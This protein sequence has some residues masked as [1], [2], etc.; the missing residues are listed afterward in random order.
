MKVTRWNCE[1]ISTPGIYSGVPMSAYHSADL[2]VGPSI[3]S[4]GLRKIFNDSPMA[5]W[6]ESP[7][8][9]RRLPE[10]D[11]EA[12]ILG[13]AAHHLILGEADF[14]KHFTL[15]PETYTNTKTGEVKTWNN[16]AT[17]C[18][19]WHEHVG[20]EGL[21]V[22]TRKQVECIRGMAGLLPWQKGL[23]D[24]G[25]LNCIVARDQLSG[26]VEHT[27]IA[28]DEETGIFLKSRPD[29][30]PLASA[31][32]ADFK[33]TTAVD[34]KS[35]QRTL[36]DLRYDM[37]ADLATTCLRQAASIEFTSHSFIFG[38]KPEP[39]A[40]RVVELKPSD[41]EEARED[42][43]IAIRTFAHC[44]ETGRW[45]GPGGTQRDAAFAERSDWSRKRAAERRA[46]LQTE[47]DVAA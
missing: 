6:V 39:H 45:P 43:R 18:R 26:L 36:D 21:T 20:A 41:L 7:L 34:D 32:F 3:S 9:P 16:N 1:P 19:E 28:R 15:E 4:S 42:N 37:Q 27:I 38:Q 40:I 14:G 23:E 10:K 33:T 17:V 5:Y 25:L 35:I 30:I 44:L 2:C 8:N 46:F 22:L 13:R 11:K 29:A 24:S 31:E 47:L 12:Y